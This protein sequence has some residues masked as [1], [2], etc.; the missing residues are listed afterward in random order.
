M[1]P[2]NTIHNT[3]LTTSTMSTPKKPT[4]IKGFQRVD[5]KWAHRELIPFLMKVYRDRH[6]YKHW[7]VAN[8]TMSVHIAE[9]HLDSIVSTRS[10]PQTLKVVILRIFCV[11]QKN[12]A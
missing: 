3:Q 11:P 1:K 4:M 2:D 9:E 12:P 7:T 6:G 8:W 10:T 5:L